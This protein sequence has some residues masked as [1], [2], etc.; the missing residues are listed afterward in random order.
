MEQ[1]NIQSRWVGI[2]EITTTYLPISKR[3]ARM[4]ASQYLHPKRIGNR[5]F[6]EREELERVLKD[7][8]NFPLD[9]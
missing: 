8:D 9:F 7:A 2:A 5:I 6:V 4:F 1:S 3:R